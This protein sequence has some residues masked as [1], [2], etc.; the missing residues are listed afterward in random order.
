MTEENQ[1]L[2]FKNITVNLVDEAK[3]KHVD[4]PVMDDISP[5]GAPVL[6]FLKGNVGKVLFGFLSCAAIIYPLVP[7]YTIFAKVLGVVVGLGGALGIA[8]PGLRKPSA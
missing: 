3:A 6:D 4:S 8:S 1:T 7:E 5:T 2:T